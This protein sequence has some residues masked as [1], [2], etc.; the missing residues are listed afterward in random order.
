MKTMMKG[1]ILALGLSALA[2]GTDLGA[3]FAEAKR[4]RAEGRTVTIVPQGAEG[5]AR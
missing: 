3:L 2:A 5:T 4:L 1:S